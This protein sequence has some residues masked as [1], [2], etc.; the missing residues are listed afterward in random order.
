MRR[1]QFLPSGFEMLADID[2]REH[3][4]LPVAAAYCRRLG[5]VEVVDRMVPFHDQGDRPRHEPHHQLDPRSEAA[6]VERQRMS[7]LGT[8]RPGCRRGAKSV[9]QRLLRQF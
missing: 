1:D 2:I 7:E 9:A 8:A 3:C 6:P 5:L 4:H